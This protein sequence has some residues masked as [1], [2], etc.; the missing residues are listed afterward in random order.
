MSKN[1]ITYLEKNRKSSLRH[2]KKRSGELKQNISTQDPELIALQKLVGNRGTQ[3]VIN[4]QHAQQTQ[5]DFGQVKN[6]QRE[7]LLTSIQLQTAKKPVPT[8]PLLPDIASRLAHWFFDKPGNPGKLS[9]NPALRKILLTLYARIGD[10][11][12]KELIPEKSITHVSEMGEMDFKTN[13]IVYVYLVLR[14]KGY[15]PSYFAKGKDEWGLREPTLPGAGLHVRGKDNK[16]NIHIDLHPPSWSGF[17]HWLMDADHWFYDMRKKTHTPETLQEGVEKLGIYIPILYEQKIH[18]E[19]TARLNRLAGQ[20]KDR[21]EVQAEI[22]EGRQYL[23]LAGKVLWTKN[24]I[25]KTELANA[26]WYL[27]LASGCASGAEHNLKRKP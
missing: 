27:G 12:W 25:S 17:Y 18:G 22:D 11:L 13:E 14:G 2:L 24:V 19:A 26:T 15:T 5:L 4:K 1:K 16:I 23:S 10:A 8:T 20:A 7:E 21:T 6:R 9:Q 3:D